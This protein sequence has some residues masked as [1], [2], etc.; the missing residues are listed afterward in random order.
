[1]REELLNEEETLKMLK[2]NKAQLENYVREGKLTPLYQ[3]SVRKFKLSDVSRVTGE[4]STSPIETSAA[5]PPFIKTQSE[6]STRVIEPPSDTTKIGIIRTGTKG[7][8]F[9]SDQETEKFLKQIDDTGST[10][11]NNQGNLIPILL[12]VALVIS[13]FSI[14]MLTFTLQGK[15]ISSITK[16]FSSLG[17]VLPIDKAENSKIE[18]EANSIIQT[19]QQTNKNAETLTKEA[20][21]FINIK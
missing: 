2:I 20:K 16:V 11:K 17:A 5:E 8:T 4:M 9:E 10:A 6:G 19:A 1:M 21:E 3:E 13:I 12:S 7:S 14:L 18:D 15:S